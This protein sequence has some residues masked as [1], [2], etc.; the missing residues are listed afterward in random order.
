MSSLFSSFPYRSLNDD[1]KAVPLRDEKH[2][3]A[4]PS[5]ETLDYDPTSNAILR[6]ELAAKTLQIYR[7]ENIARWLLTFLIGVAIGV[8]AWLIDLGVKYLSSIKFRSALSTYETHG[9]ARG[10]ACFLGIFFIIIINYYY[11]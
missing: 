2:R 8:T 9:F 11:Y 6:E 5:I 4:E 3:P 10:F 1:P 7:K